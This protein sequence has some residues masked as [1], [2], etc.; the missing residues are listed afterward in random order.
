MIGYLSVKNVGEKFVGGVL[1]V[2]ERGIPKEFKYTK[3]I[4]PTKLQR[5]IYGKVLEKY[6]SVEI[7]AKALLSK[8]E[9]KPSVILTD[10]IDLTESDERVFFISKTSPE[11]E[12]GLRKV[13]EG[14]YVLVVD[15]GAYR[16]V[17]NSELS[18]EASSEMEEFAR[19]LNILEPFQ[20]LSK[21][22]DYVCSEL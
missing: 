21:A 16:L 12:E 1:I 5:I 4:S 19:N 7:I 8:I 17:G 10:E 15:G 14:E 18:E 2:D 9:N 13:E 20:R 22:L 3:P 6:L 11:G